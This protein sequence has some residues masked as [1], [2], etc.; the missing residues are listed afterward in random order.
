MPDCLLHELLIAKLATYGFDYDSF[1]FIQSYLSER[2]QRTKINNACNTYSDI[3]YGVP[4]GSK[5]GPLI[6]NIYISDVFYDIDICEI[7]SY[8]DDSTPYTSDFNLKKVTQ[9]LDLTTNNL[10]EWF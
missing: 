5:L 9:K 2:Q 4:Q 1:V 3:L 8:A 6:F 7:A 10:F